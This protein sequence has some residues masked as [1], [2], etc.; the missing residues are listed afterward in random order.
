MLSRKGNFEACKAHVQ[1]TIYFQ[2]YSYV[3]FNDFPGADY[4]TL[5]SG[6][7]GV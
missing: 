1:I 5:V 6:G 2:T 7:T 3:L 4:T